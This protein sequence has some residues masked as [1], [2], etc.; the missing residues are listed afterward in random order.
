MTTAPPATS[1]R[2]DHVDETVLD[3]LVYFKLKARLLELLVQERDIN[4]ARV[5][6][7]IEAGVR[8]GPLDFDDATCTVRRVG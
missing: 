6:V 7:L 8:P 1:P 4:A 3:P 2:G 5:A